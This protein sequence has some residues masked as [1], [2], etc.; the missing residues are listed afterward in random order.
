MNLLDITPDELRRLYATDNPEVHDALWALTQHP[1]YAFRPRPDDPNEFDQQT[2]FLN[3]NE[4]LFAICLGGTGSGKTRTAAQK[5]ADFVLERK[6]PRERCPFWIIGE[7]MDQICQAAWVEKLSEIIPDNEIHSTVWYKPKRKWPESVLLRHPDKFNEVGWILEFK[8]YEQGFRG[9]KAISIGG[10]WCN[11]EIPFHLVQ[12]IRGRCRDYDSPGWADFTPVECRDPEWPMAYDDPPRGW[13]F[14]HLNSLKNDAVPPGADKPIS[15]WAAAY[16]DG[17]PADMRDMRQY[18]RFTALQGAVYKEFRKSTHVISYDKFF[19]L[20]GHRTIPRHWRKIRGLD[21]GYNNPFVCLWIARDQDDRYYVYDEHYQAQGLVKHHAERINAREWDATQPWYGPTYSEHDPQIRAELTQFGITTTPANKAESQGV[22]M[23]RR[24]MMIKGDDRPQ[25]YV[26]EHCRNLIREI[27]AARWPEGT[28]LRNPQDVPI[29]KDNHCLAAGT[30]IETLGG[31]LPI[32]MVQAGQMVL[33]RAGWQDVLWSGPTRFDQTLCVTLSNGKVLNGTADHRV[34]V[35]GYGWKAI[36]ELCQGDEL[37]EV[38]CVRKHGEI[39]ALRQSESSLTASPTGDIPSLPIGRFACTSLLRRG[40]GSTSRFGKITTS[41]P[42]LTDATFI[43]RTKTPSTIPSTT[44][45]ARLDFSIFRIMQSL[46]GLTLSDEQPPQKR[47]G[48][49]TPRITPRCTDGGG[50]SGAELNCQQLPPSSGSRFARILAF[51]KSA[52]LPTRRG[53]STETIF[54]R[55][56]AEPQQDVHPALTTS[57][58]FAR[59]ARR[60]SLSIDTGNLDTARVHVLRVTSTG[61]REQTYDLTVAGCP[62]FFANGVLV[63]NSTDALRYAIFTDRA[64]RR[65]GHKGF[66]KRPDYA[67]R[68]VLITGER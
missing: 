61:R 52:G 7:T 1:Y 27:I 43:T 48:V 58:V 47:C 5:T 9:M 20:T 66:K 35:S 16:L 55:E 32:E 45:N 15:E 53:S 65:G 23:L 67:K 21:F 46:C 63:H 42:F 12:E 56:S 24:L 2:S 33:T 64:G 50:Q 49:E 51:A 36:G 62:E 28:S 26:F 18:G 25:L 57:N 59:D 19:E 60:P 44:W 6:P 68:G 30:L 41:G 13:K 22:E 31:E 3:D 54:V 34:W 37:I 39:L 11:E 8:S 17:V 10:F 14:Y 38:E 4:S 29:D 40:V